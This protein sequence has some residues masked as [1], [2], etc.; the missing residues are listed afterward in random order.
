M[1]VIAGLLSL[2]WDLLLPGKDTSETQ[3]ALQVVANTRPTETATTDWARP[4]TPVPSEP[5]PAWPATPSPQQPSTS[6]VEQPPP[7]SAR[8]AS[9]PVRE[10]FVDPYITPGYIT[11]YFG[12]HT[13]LQNKRL[14]DS[15]IGKKIEV[16]GELGNSSQY[17]RNI[18]GIYASAHFKNDFSEEYPMIIMLFDEQHVEMLAAIQPNAMLTVEGT[19]WR[20]DRYSL[21]L[22]DCRI[23]SVGGKQ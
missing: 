19:I 22:I 5:A 11:E 1:T 12:G 9:I 18:G 6:N 16:T 7:P 8:P 4:A 23:L 14:A 13:D 2:S 3:S 21:S 17:E 10:G 15:I 20:I